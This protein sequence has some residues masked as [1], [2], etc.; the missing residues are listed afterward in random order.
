MVLPSIE[1]ASL[2]EDKAGPEVIQ[3][4]YTFQDRGGRALALRPEGTATLQELARTT[5]KFRKDIRLWYET[6]CWRYERPQAGR[7]REFSQFGVEVLNPSYDWLP[8]LLDLAVAMVQAVTD[9]YIVNESV[10]RGLAYYTGPG[11][12]IVCPALGA[13]Q[14]VC[15]GGRYAEGAGFALGVDRLLLVS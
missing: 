15:G 13:Q 8:T 6:R 14:Q 3:Q 4:M 12:E 11:F 1:I 9:Q 10:R 2:Y 7:Y 5:L